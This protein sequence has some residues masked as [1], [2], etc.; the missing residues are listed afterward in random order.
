MRD[1]SALP[2]CNQGTQAERQRPELNKCL[3]VIQLG[4]C[5]SSYGRY[6]TNSRHS[7][8]TFDLDQPEQRK[9]RAMPAFGRPGLS[10]TLIAD[11]LMTSIAFR[12]LR[13]ATTFGN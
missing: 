1:L 9:N 12:N 10:R 5:R 7:L 3:G 2:A 11:I 8:V 6:F 4:H 13:D